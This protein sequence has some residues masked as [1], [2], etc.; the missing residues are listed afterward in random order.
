MI[1]IK[2]MCNI[3][4]VNKEHRLPIGLIVFLEATFKELHEAHDPEVDVNHF[5]LE[6]HG[7]IYV[8]ENGVD[9]LVDLG[10]IGLYPP[11]NQIMGYRPEWVER[12]NLSGCCRYWRIGVMAD[13]DYLFQVILPADVF[14]RVVDQW[15]REYLDDGELLTKPCMRSNNKT[16]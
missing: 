8:L 12:I 16:D 11:K 13:N 9:T 6:M 2:T 5:S 10:K 14:G 7:P 3:A 1:T 4:D 15:L